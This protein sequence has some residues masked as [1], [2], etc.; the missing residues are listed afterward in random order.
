MKVRHLL[1][2]I[3][4]LGM[5]NYV[6]KHQLV[7]SG[8]RMK[9]YVWKYMLVVSTMPRIIGAGA[10]P[11]RTRSDRS[12]ALHRSDQLQITLLVADLSRAAA[13]S[14]VRASERRRVSSSA[15]TQ[16]T[17]LATWTS[18]QAACAPLACC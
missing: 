6:C 18:A 14:H 3:L 15:A 16:I 11:D 10:D 7:D 1:D 4:N 8:F 12:A 5:K 2:R 13:C 9:N 17:C